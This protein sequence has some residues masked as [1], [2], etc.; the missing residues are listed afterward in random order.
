MQTLIKIWTT[1]L[2][3]RRQ[4]PSEDVNTYATALQELYRRVETNTFAYP[5]AIKDSLQFIH[6]IKP[7]SKL[8]VVRNCESSK[9]S[10]ILYITI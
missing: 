2:E 1:E 5:K 8:K 4:Q 10:Y 6:K 7:K 9:Y 3:Q